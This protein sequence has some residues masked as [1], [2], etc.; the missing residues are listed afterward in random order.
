MSSIYPGIA[1]TASAGSSTPSPDLKTSREGQSTLSLVVCPVPYRGADWMIP[2][3]LS[4]PMGRDALMDHGDVTGVKSRSI[5]SPWLLQ[6][7]PSHLQPLS[8]ADSWPWSSAQPEGRAKA[9]P[10]SSLR[11]AD[12]HSLCPHECC[13]ERC[14]GEKNP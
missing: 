11:G 7:N 6:G 3:V 5:K 1:P 14:G 13:I 9:W 4:G 12:N 8:Q 2:A 10:P